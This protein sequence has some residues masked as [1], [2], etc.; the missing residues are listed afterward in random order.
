MNVDIIKEYI[1]F[2]TIKEDLNRT[3]VLNAIQIDSELFE[4]FK[5]T[6]IGTVLY[7]EAKLIKPHKS[8]KKYVARTSI[9]TKR[10][11]IG[12]YDSYEAATNAIFY[13]RLCQF[14]ACVTTCGYSPYM[15]KKTHEK[16]FI[17]P[18]G[19]V[20]NP[21]GRKLGV[22]INRNG[23]KFVVLGRNGDEFLHRLIAEAFI[24]NPNN[25]PIINH[26]DGNKLNN[27]IEN[28][29]WCTHSQNTLHAYETGLTVGKKC[30]PALSIKEKEYIR[31]HLLEASTKIAKEI[32]RSV[33]TV[34]RQLR[35]Y[36]KM[37]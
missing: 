11:F 14:A 4:I 8:K 31:Q 21:F 24:P 29:E 9:L 25:L 17:W 15:C 28:L 18:D 19:A 36:R 13:Y 33:A 30:A 7:N 37:L 32:N 20:F 1:T 2:N 34:G 3:D 12:L 16:Y 26:I 10:I 22:H 23:Y 35:K 6:E 27:S 5:N